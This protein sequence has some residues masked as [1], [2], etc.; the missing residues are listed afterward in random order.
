MILKSDKN[1]M[2]PLHYFIVFLCVMCFSIGVYGSD[3]K[4]KASANKVAPAVHRST[5]RGAKNMAEITWHFSNEILHD[6]ECYGLKNSKLEMKEGNNEWGMTDYPVDF[7]GKLIKFTVPVKPCL[8]Y[9]FRIK[10]FTEDNTPQETTTAVSLPSLDDEQTLAT[11]YQPEDPLEFKALEITKNS[12]KVTWKKSDCAKSYEIIYNVP[13]SEEP[14][15][16]KSSDQT[17]ATLS[18]LKPCT[19]YEAEIYSIL[20]SN[21]GQSKTQF[22]TKP[23]LDIRDKF[24]VREKEDSTSNTVTL[25]WDTWQ[26]VSCIEE[27][28]IKTCIENT[29]CCIKERTINKTVDPSKF[30]PSVMFKETGLDDK[31]SYT[32]RIKPIYKGMDLNVKEH[33]VRLGETQDL[34]I[35]KDGGAVHFPVESTTNPSSIDCPVAFEFEKPK[36][37]TKQ[38]NGGEK[39]KIQYLPVAFISLMFN[40]ITMLRK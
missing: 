7:P 33:V 11:G 14:N 13:G 29:K 2:F 30:H 23:G 24:N 18:D 3:C 4:K 39:L 25:S 20:G 28:K 35:N 21:E 6:R 40:L 19:T 15:K 38:T 16:Q 17:F 9:E 36:P 10:L 31:K 37:P 12:A 5:R 34:A 1:T 26:N 22:S 32:F 8:K 27:Y